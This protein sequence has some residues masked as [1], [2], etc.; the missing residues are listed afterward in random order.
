VSS[1]EKERTIYA[2]FYFSREKKISKPE[3]SFKGRN[4]L[5]C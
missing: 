4:T 1:Y 5:K 3:T 2:H